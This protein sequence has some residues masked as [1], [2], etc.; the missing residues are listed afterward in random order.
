VNGGNVG[1]LEI[2]EENA[3]NFMI[4][5]AFTRGGNQWGTGPYAVFE[6][7]GT[8]AV[9]TITVSGVPTGGS[10]RLRYGNQT[11]AAIAYNATAGAVADALNALSNV[12]DGSFSA[13][14]GA[15][16]GNPVVV[17]FGGALGSEPQ[18]LLVVTNSALTGGTNPAVSV[19]NTTTGVDGAAGVLPVALDPLDHL[20]VM[21]TEIVAPDSDDSPNDMPALP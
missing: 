21:M 8:D 10:F 3:I 18:P 2:T 7:A 9:Q 12:P 6:G 14:G 16:P 5:G 11:T 4:T 13:T 15:F 19:A 20:L 17:T 1:D